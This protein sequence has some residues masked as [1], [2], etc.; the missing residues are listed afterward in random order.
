M[1][2]IKYGDDGL[3]SKLEAWADRVVEDAERGV[4]ETALVIQ[5]T[6]KSNIS[7]DTGFGRSSIGATFGGLEAQVHASANYLVYLEYGTGVYATKG[8]RAK[9]IP[10]SYKD[11]DGQWHTTYGM[12]PQPFW[13]PA[14]LAG[15][16]YF[17][18]Y[19]S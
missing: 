1:A 11:A 19:F 2:H 4:T 9:S 12:R 16:A 8:S 5:S 7:V 10:W 18:N 3:T 6:A 13:T 15:K 14:L 17:K